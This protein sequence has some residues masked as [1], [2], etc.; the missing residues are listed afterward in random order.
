MIGY[1]ALGRN[2]RLGNQMFQYAALKGIAANRGYE[3]CV[4]PQEFE[5]QPENHL[6]FDFFEMPDIKH[7]QFMPREPG[8]GEGY[9]HFNEDL[10]NNCPDNVNLGGYFQTE[11]YFLH[12]AND[13]KRDFTF[14]QYIQDKAKQYLDKLKAE[15]G[16]NLICLSVRR[17]DYIH[18]PDHHPLCTLD[19]YR[20]ALSR[21][22]SDAHVVLISDDKQW[23]S[24]Q[25][26]FTGE[27]FHITNREFHYS[28]DMCIT[29]M[30]D[31]HIISNSTFSWW[32][33]WLSNKKQV[34]APLRWFG[35]A[36]DYLDT[37]DLIPSEW[38]RI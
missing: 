27:R 30:I 10:F 2:G 36:Y 1:N 21:F 12:I 38:E 24:E 13:V 22:D 34:V 19:Y 29:S 11:K 14:K 8:V 4:P 20:E 35:T 6:L 28:I 26:L 31:K 16:D 9:F 17:G 7:I 25:E 3:Y 15:H 37:K 5:P 18:Y 32:G 23:V 33:T